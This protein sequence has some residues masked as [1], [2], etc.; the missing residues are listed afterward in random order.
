MMKKI[1]NEFPDEINM[2]LS[3]GNPVNHLKIKEGQSLIDL[4]CGA[5]MDIFYYKDEKS[6]S[7]NFI[8]A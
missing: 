6:K 8:W 3:C 1:I 4:G 5:G 2:G 7:R